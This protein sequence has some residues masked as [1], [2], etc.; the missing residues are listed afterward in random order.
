M[1]RFH[2]SLPSGKRVSHAHMGTG[3]EPTS[4]LTRELG[5]PCT[6][7]DRAGRVKWCKNRT[8]SPMHT[9]GQGTRQDSDLFVI[10]GLPCTHGDR[11]PILLEF[12]RRGGLPCTHGNRVADEGQNG[13]DN[14]PAPPA[15]ISDRRIFLLPGPPNR[16]EK[17]SSYFTLTAG[18]IHPHHEQEALRPVDDSVCLS[19]L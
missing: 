7:G 4:N 5:L 11:I 17:I 12:L 9:W 15:A 3:V 8:G 19:V 13:Q 10:Q 6:H 16:G 18:D 2:R 1:L 14:A